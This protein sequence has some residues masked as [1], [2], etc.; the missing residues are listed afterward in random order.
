MQAQ[1][2]GLHG[3]RVNFIDRVAA[4]HD[5]ADLLDCDG[6]TEL[7]FDSVPAFEQAFASPPGQTA[8]LDAEAHCAQRLRYLTREIVLW[9]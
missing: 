5:A 1:I 3:Y 6:C 4:S 9:P 8:G 7:W 2:P